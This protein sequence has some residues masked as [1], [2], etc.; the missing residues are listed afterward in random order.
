MWLIYGTLHKILKL[1]P[2]A[3]VPEP[4]LAFT[5]T[6]YQVIVTYNILVLSVSS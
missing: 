1:I 3:Y 5:F 6:L 2:A 4:E